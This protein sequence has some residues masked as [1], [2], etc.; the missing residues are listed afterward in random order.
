MKIIC[1]IVA[2]NIP[3]LLFSQEG[4][5]DLENFAERLYQI[6]D[7]DLAYDQIYESLLQYYIHPINLNKTSPD[8]LLSLNILTPIQ[9]NNLFDHLHNNG[10]LLSIYELQSIP[11]F[12]PEVIS[13][14]IPFVTVMEKDDNRNLWQRIATEDNNYL[15]LRH[16]RT[17]E[18][19]KGY[20]QSEENPYFG[21]PNYFYARY[22]ISRSNDFSLGFTLEKDP[23]EK[24]YRHD[25]SGMQVFDF[26]SFHIYFKNQGIIK[27]LA[28]GD[29]QIQLGQGLVFG[30]G[31]SFGKGTETIHTTRRND[32]GL[33]PYTSSLESGFFRG[34]GITLGKRSWNYTFLYSNTNQD[35]NVLTDTT[36]TDFDEYVSSIQSSGYHR[37]QNELNRKNRLNEQIMGGA[38][39]YNMRNFTVGSTYLFSQFNYPIQK[40]PNNYNQFEFTGSRN[41]VGSIYGSWLWQNFNFFGEYARSL[42][43]GQAF[44]AGAIASLAPTVDFS[45][46]LRNYDKDFHSF[47]GN[48]FGEQSR[49][50]NEK[51][52]Y[53]GLKFTPHRKMTLALYF[54]YFNFPWLKYGVDAPSKGQEYLGRLTYR[55]SKK[56]QFYTQYREES[57]ETSVNKTSGNLGFLANGIKR[58]LLIN[59]DYQVSNSI[60]MKTR[61]QFSSFELMDN[62]TKGF[63]IIQDF[64]Y[65]FWRLK[66]DARFAIFETDNYDNRIYAYERDLLYS[67]SIPAYSGNGIRSY[68][69]VRYNINRFLNIWVKYSRF[70]YA[71]QDTIG[72]GSEE[73]NGSVRSDIRTMIKINF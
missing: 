68:L 57:K 44:Y 16:Y 52:A 49:T 54:D 26:Q 17:L 32:L 29:F 71:Y 4:E 19:K 38:I 18:S 1:L 46:S 23:G 61:I 70:N 73:I 41:W 28:L 2:L 21:D 22:R 47:Y 27:A 13:D 30:S 39:S 8:Q 60:S 43:G 34:A 31:F 6:Q 45:F 33:R 3:I 55:Q 37:N 11:L 5:L 25:S 59:T 58:N 66:V 9:V 24:I 50:I 12:T 35:A 69:M 62:R 14:L 15:I 42:S 7:D 72:S 65:A 67:F 36:F 20:K 51:G 56:I 64:R 48:G 10:A 63:A 40:K 53:W